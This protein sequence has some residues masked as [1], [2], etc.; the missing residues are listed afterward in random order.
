MLDRPGVVVG[1]L[2]EDKSAPGKILDIADLDTLSGQVPVSLIDIGHDEL[3]ALMDPGGLSTR[4]LPMAIEQ[5]EPG[6]VN[7]TKRISSLTVWS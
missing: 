1:I 2:K 6:G 4:P 7:C 5:A 3:Q